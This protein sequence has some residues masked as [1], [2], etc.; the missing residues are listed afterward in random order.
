MRY[1]VCII[2][3]I[4]L[5]INSQAQ[6]TMDLMDCI[7]LSKTHDTLIVQIPEGSE[8]ELNYLRSGQRVYFEQ[9]VETNMSYRVSQAVANSGRY[10]KKIN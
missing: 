10:K 5:V 9:R 7:L 8:L 6:V 1:L 4:V 2:L 3:S